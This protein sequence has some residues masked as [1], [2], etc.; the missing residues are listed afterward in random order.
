MLR[1]EHIVKQYAGHTALDDISISTKKGEIF[2]LL[3]PNGAG[4]TTLFK[5]MADQLK[6][7]D[8]TIRMGASVKLSLM[9]KRYLKAG[10]SGRVRMTFRYKPQFLQEG[11]KFVFREGKTKGIGTITKVLAYA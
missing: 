3:G 10:E 5:L 11:A 6:P 2:G 8:G 4:K 9:D 7:M 1:V